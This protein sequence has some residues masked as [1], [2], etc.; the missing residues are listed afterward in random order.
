MINIQ[1][2]GAGAGKT[3]GL[4][5]E[6]V[7]YCNQ[8]TSSK[9]TY[10]ITFTNAAKKKIEQEVISQ[11]GF[12]PSCLEI[13]TIHTFLLNEVIYPY[14]HYVTPDMY[15]QASVAPLPSDI[16]FKNHKI[17]RLK[18]LN[19]IHSSKVFSVA[20][21]ILD[22]NHSSQNTRA[23]KLKVDKIILLIKSCV[24]RIYLDEVQDLDMDAL[25]AFASLGIEGLYI[26]MIGDPKQ[27][28]KY[29]KALTQFLDNIQASHPEK[30]NIPEPNNITRRVPTEILTV[31]NP[32]CYPDQ[33]QQSTS[34][35]VG[36]LLYIDS[37]HQDFDQFIRGHIESDSL[38]CIDKKSGNY[39]TVKTTSGSFD[40]A[41]SEMIAASKHGRDPEL[42]VKVA[43]AE[44]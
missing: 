5:Q 23:K 15:N 20:R 11:L 25:R 19:V 39:T 12:M 8:S 9:I 30:T 28:I 14:S 17:S 6:L 31:S 43:H 41:V 1:I 13:E 32:F 22:R 40:P 27:S 34:D 38:V 18:N 16:R 3:Y 7:E 35:E 24:E 29:P 2:A 10:A 37:T 33:Q 21:K 4:A 42:M 44:F 36:E 26:Y